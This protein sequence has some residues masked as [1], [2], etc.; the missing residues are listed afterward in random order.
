M[1]K[2]ELNLTRLELEVLRIYL[3]RYNETELDHYNYKYAEKTGRIIRNK[4][5]F[6]YNIR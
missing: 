6:L 5:E 1:A 3:R 2:I 4:I